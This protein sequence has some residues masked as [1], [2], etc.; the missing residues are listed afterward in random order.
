LRSFEALVAEHERERL[1]LLANPRVAN[2]RVANSA[3]RQGSSST[4]KNLGVRPTRNGRAGP[5][6]V[7]RFVS[8]RR[9]RGAN[10]SHLAGLSID[11]PVAPEV[12]GHAAAQASWDASIERVYGAKRVAPTKTRPAAT[13]PAARSWDASIER[14]YGGAGR[15]ADPRANPRIQR[16][17]SEA[18][19]K[20]GIA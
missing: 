3:T 10:F 6:T 13:T 8:D 2:P 1:F 19:R 4:D 5:A 18:F 17:W 14:V 11:I 16:G 7:A 20:A 9:R 15:L 12:S